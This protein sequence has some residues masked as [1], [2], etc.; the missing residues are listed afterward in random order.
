MQMNTH[1]K[2]I[3]WIGCLL[4]LAGGCSRQA[5]TPA[6]VPVIF[7][8]DPGNDIDDVLALQ[9]LL[10]YHRQGRI[11]LLGI[12]IG[13]MYPRAIEYVDAYCRHNGL[14]DVPL[15]YVY[16]GANPLPEAGDYV[17]RTL[18]TLIGG[19][20][21]L[22][23]A[24]SIADRIPEGYRLYRRLL[25]EAADSSVV[26]IAVGP[27]TNVA[28]LLESPADEIS[29]LT[30]RELVARKVRLLSLMGGTYN[31]DVFNN[32]EWNVMQ[33]LG[34]SRTL[35]AEWPTPL[36]ASGSEVGTRILYPASSVLRDFEGGE[37]APLCVSY[38][39]YKPM[40]YDRP[41]WDLTSV[42]YAVEPD[43]SFLGISEPGTI[44]VSEAG[45]SRFTPDPAGRHCFL[46]V[47][48]DDIPGVVARL[49]ETCAERRT[50]TDTN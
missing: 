15:G 31:D 42:L 50:E 25:A 35:F 1:M 45:Y 4:L 47:A 39:I 23:P 28:R 3:A 46:T 29:P 17:I 19:R 41:A 32:P 33:D 16:D 26:F 2:Y 18:D 44:T 36:V 6:P 34:A 20:R 30:G 7:D 9:M 21:I 13:K 40:P 37:A 8:T 5:E 27:Y 49:V 24:R 43:R 14:D 11:D 22:T 12:G 10:N 48:P 38:K